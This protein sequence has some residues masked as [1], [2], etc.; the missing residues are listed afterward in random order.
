MTAMFV[1]ISHDSSFVAEGYEMDAYLADYCICENPACT[2]PVV[3]SG[4]FCSEDCRSSS[5]GTGS[6]VCDCGHSSCSSN[7]SLPAKRLA[8]VRKA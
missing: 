4:T 2:C 5:D 1:D 8:A 3:E 6:L 7:E